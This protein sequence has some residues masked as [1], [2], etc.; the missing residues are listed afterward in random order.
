MIHQIG[1]DVGLEQHRAQNALLRLHVVG[2]VDAHTFEIQFVVMSFVRH[3]I[4]FL[5][6]P[7]KRPLP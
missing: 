4:V 2:Q 3:D 6:K 7:K 1:Q 5:L